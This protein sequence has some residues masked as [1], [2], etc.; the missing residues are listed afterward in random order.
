MNQR[1]LSALV[2][3]DLSAAFDTIDHQILLARLSSTFGVT[4][5]A[6]NLLV[7][8]L[9]SRAQFVSINSTSTAPSP[10]LTGVPQ[11]SVLGPLLF[12]LYTTPLSYIISSTPVSYHF[13]A[14]DTQLYISFN[15]SDSNHSLTLLS[16]ILDSVHNWLISNKLSVNPSKTEYL[17][18]G[19][20]QQR[21]KLTNTSISFQGTTLNPTESTRNLG[22]IFDQDLSLKQHISSLCK[23]SYY[24]I[25]QI[26]QI[27]NSLDLNSATLLCKLLSFL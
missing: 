1:K 16:S 7:S 14:D 9:S 5:S 22:V 19:T 17:I 12:C 11:G 13:Y 6:H 3:L 21:A 18:I 25:R 20:P 24:Q 26:R 8:Y 27:R 4:G 2:L 15:S 10:M 23:S